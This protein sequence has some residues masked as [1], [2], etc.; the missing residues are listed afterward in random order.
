MTLYKHGVG[1]FERRAALTGAEV[2]LSFRVEEMNDILKSLTAIDWGD[3]QVLGIDYATPQSREER[4]AGCSVRLSDT[5]S[6]RDLL[7]G[8]RGR[9]VSLHLDQGET[10]V[11]SLLGLD[12]LPER[13]PVGDS[14]VSLL[15]DEAEQVQTFSLNRVQSA[16]ILD[17]R[18]AADLRFFLQVAQTQEKYRKVTIRLTPGEHDLS[19]SYIAPA[20]TWRVSY[21]LVADPE[22]EGGPKALLLGWGIFDNRLEEELSEISLSLVAGMPISFVYDLYTP[23]TPERP[24]IE[25][26]SRVA[27]GP[28]D[29]V[30]GADAFAAA[31]PLQMRAMGVSAAPSAQPMARKMSRKEMADS[32]SVSASGEAMGELFQYHITTPVSVGRG[33]SA[34]VPILATTLGYRKELIYNSAKL[35]AHPIAT[36]RTT[37]TTGLTLERGPATVIE[38]GDYVGEAVLPFTADHAEFIIPYAVELG[39]RVREQ[40]GAETQLYGLSIQGAFLLFEEWD[41]R[42]R[43]YQINNTTGKPL[44]ILIEHPRNAYYDLFDTP[45]PAETTEESVRFA[46]EV[47]AKT[48]LTLRVNTRRLR[49]RREEIQQQSYVNLQRYLSKGLIDRGAHDFIAQILSLLEKINKHKQ[50]IGEIDQERQ[51][52]YDAQKQIQGNMQA[53]TSDG[54]EGRV[55][56]QYVDRLEATE[57]SLHVLGQEEAKLKYEIERL[58]K[59]MESIIGKQR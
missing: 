29:L 46:V 42:W 9:R 54:K 11:G 39:V 17:E 43:E 56:S 6:L 23:F 27:P 26:E 52:V 44:D 15:L 41:I 34:M 14:L 21:R 51:K 3:G 22:A 31:E 36:L 49:Q 33:Q 59:E 53:L 35:A 25:E 10:A 57:N 1:F 16:D 7:V 38:G 2:S 18:G 20:P 58:E 19:V 45:A 4:L 12:E 24:L 28:I 48:E 30:A 8:L 5:R 50:R 40:N 13:Q 47:G 37:N 55:R 32:V